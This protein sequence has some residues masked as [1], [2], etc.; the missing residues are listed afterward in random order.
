MRTLIL[1]AAALAVLAGLASVAYVNSVF[2]KDI[3]VSFASAEV[4]M[5]KILLLPAESNECQRRRVLDDFGGAIDNIDMV[6]GKTKVVVF[7][8][9]PLIHSETIYYPVSDRK[10]C[11]SFAK[12]GTVT[13][14]KHGQMFTFS[15]RDAT[16]FKPVRER[17]Y[18]PDGK[19]ISAGNLVDGG[20]KFQT[21]FFSTAGLTTRSE[22]YNLTSKTLESE[23][24]YRPDGTALVRQG[25]NQSETSFNREH[26]SA[27]GKV[28]VSK[29]DRSYGRYGLSELYPNGKTRLEAARS[30]D[31]NYLMLYRPD[32][33]QELRVQMFSDR[34]ITVNHYDSAGKPHLETRW[35]ESKSGPVDGNGYRPMVLWRFI[36]TNDQG[37]PVRE[38]DLHPDRTIKKV[39]VYKNFE[40]AKGRQEYTF[41]ASGQ[42]VSYKARDDN[43]K[44]LPEVILTPGA[45]PTFTVPDSYFVL[46][47]FSLP[48]G[49]Y[50]YDDKISK[51][52]QYHGGH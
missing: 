32:G 49:L 5:P 6:D 13:V 20:N 42:A 18:S 45:G 4:A 37:K 15:E 2:D 30:I 23:T 21:D 25:F 41:N 24:L 47:P 26:F 9:L 38:V 19:A 11:E 28:V 27:D 48:A 40:Y 35:R 33:T 52:I 1:S 8:R 7:Q 22:T 36:E 31:Y 17:K 14:S 44:E 51:E 39:T 3:T 29:E 46:K 12:D 34:S 10:D 16:G 43:G 50:K